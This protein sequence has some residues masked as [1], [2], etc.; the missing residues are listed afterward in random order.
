MSGSKYL[1]WCLPGNKIFL[2]EGFYRLNASIESFEVYHRDMLDSLA[3]LFNFP[4]LP[5]LIE[6]PGLITSSTE[7]KNYLIRK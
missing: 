6:R 7:H 3:L 5:L 4:L 1:N 2:F